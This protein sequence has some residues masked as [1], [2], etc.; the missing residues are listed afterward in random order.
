MLKILLI[1]DNPADARLIEEL[2]KEE[3]K[4]SYHLE[5]AEKLSR[6]LERL[7]V[8]HF[9]VV[10]LDLGLPDS[11][12]LDTLKAVVKEYSRLPTIVV[13]GLDDEATAIA[14]MRHGAQD[15]LL[16]GRIDS[17]VLW[18]VMNYA[19]KRKQ[20]EES[21]RSE[22]MMLARTEGIAHL[23]SWEWDIASDTVTWSDE[24]FRIF[25]RDPQEGAPSFAEHPAF[26]HPGDMARLRQAV[27]IAVA[28]GTPYELELRVIRKDGQTRVCIARGVAEM[29]PGGRPVRLFGSL[30]DITE[31]K[32]AEEKLR[33]S[34]E[35]FR[36]AQ[37][38]SPDGFTILH[39]LRNEKGEIIDFT[40][41][42]ENKTIAGI[43][44]TDPEEVK[45]KRLLDLFPTHKGSS[46]FE[47]YVYVSNS[48]KPQ[49][50]EEVYVGE[51]VSRPTWLRL[52]IV[53]MGE[54]IAILAQDSTER[55]N[56]EEALRTSEAR[57]R[58]LA[59]HTTDVIRLLDMDL[60]T[61][62][63]SPSA[64]KLRGFTL[65]EMVEMPLERQLT[66]ESLRTA[67]AIFSEEIPRVETDPG[68]N[69]I[70]TLDLEY[71]C[72]DGT[73]I[74]TESKFSVIRDENSR[75]VSILTEARDISER[76]RAEE[77]LLKSFES[78]RKTLNDAISTMVKMVEM[79]DP[80]TAG[81]QQRVADLATT[82]AREMKLEDTRIEQ[83]RMASA[84]HDI[85]KM[86]IPSDILS[87][88]GRLSDIE[89]GLIKTH[90]QC[91]YDVVKG[92]DFPGVVA[93]AV[94]QHHE[95]LD[96]SGYPNGL[97]GEDTLLEAKILA[98]ADV[99]EAMASHRPYRPALGIDKALEELSKNRGKLYDPDAVDICLRLF[100]EK[101]FSFVTGAAKPV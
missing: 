75:A 21:R 16:K 57:Y 78:L 48:G 31:R 11:K 61:A 74:W 35:W 18:R 27:E 44:G 66:P 91:G 53:S 95:R 80:Y 101:L 36:V 9:D 17:S 4:D 1:E 92:M 72:K 97:K 28:E 49:I 6:G 22:Q 76:K 69:P 32:R 45:G 52:V 15:Y 79:R 89:F 84:I 86:Y 63:L 67:Y 25:Q 8:D 98:V 41:V 2:L 42:Y 100:K 58:L 56:V 68:Y 82:I 47:A 65:Q 5:Q 87:K 70:F 83:L 94:L 55:K 64:E 13:T 99:I 33:E 20:A 73:T 50:I 90:A 93:Q 19:I 85:G 38:M 88:P 71:Y 39:P 43:N 54:Y 3:A 59:E 96:G 34:E 40:W 24:L 7:A 29:A 14:A 46:V 37:E 10:F 60:K 77:K 12:G 81:H 26:Y 62:Y 23:G 51:I 30:Q